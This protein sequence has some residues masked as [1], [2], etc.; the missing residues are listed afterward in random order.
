VTKTRCSR[1]SLADPSVAVDD[2]GLAKNLLRSVGSDDDD[3]DDAGGARVRALN[4]RDARQQP[5]CPCTS[6]S[7]SAWKIS[8]GVLTV[9]TTDC[10]LCWAHLPPVVDRCENCSGAQTTSQSAAHRWSTPGIRIT[11]S[12]DSAT[13]PTSAWIHEDDDA[14]DDDVDSASVT[15]K[16]RCSSLATDI[17]SVSSP[18]PYRSVPDIARNSLRGNTW[19]ARATPPPPCRWTNDRWLSAGVS[20]LP[21]PTPARHADVHLLPVCLRC[22]SN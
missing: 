13:F 10:P 16:R 3:D 2:G 1:R 6:T 14:P 12:T 22:P 20:S 11:S 21:R 9:P 5:G 19:R 4:A 7:S 18:L 17:D 8:A 15:G